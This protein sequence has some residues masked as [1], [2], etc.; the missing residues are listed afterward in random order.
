[1]SVEIQWQRLL[2]RRGFRYVLMLLGA[3]LLYQ[4][5]GLQ[6]LGN[7]RNIWRQEAEMQRQIEALREENARIE[8][9]IRDL[10]PEGNEVERIARQ[11]LGWARPGETVIKIP[12]KK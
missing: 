4:V 2:S 5:S 11:D 3:L 1:M 9:E 10:S 12:E 8:N 7:L 6:V